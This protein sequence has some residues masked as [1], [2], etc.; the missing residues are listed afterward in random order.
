MTPKYTD[1]TAA[2][3]AVLLNLGQKPLPIPQPAPPTPAP[4]PR[5][6]G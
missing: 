3:I 5:P 6:V 2:G 4:A 1:L